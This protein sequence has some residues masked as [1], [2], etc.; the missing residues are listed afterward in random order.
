MKSP[1]READKIGK[2]TIQTYPRESG[3]NEYIQ[4][5]PGLPQ[6]GKSETDPNV[7]YPLV[8]NNFKIKMKYTDQPGT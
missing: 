3:V 5:L 1:S 6:N 8:K 7:P 2:A 4:H